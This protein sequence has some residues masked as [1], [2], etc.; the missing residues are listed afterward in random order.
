M[1]VPTASA[2][3]AL[4]LVRGESALPHDLLGAHPITRDGVDGV[5]IRAFQ[6]N[7][8]S[9]VVVLG[10]QRWP[11][12]R[13][14]HGL[15]AVFL[16]DRTAP[17]AYRL[18]ITFGDGRTVLRDDPYRFLPTLGE[19]DLHLFNEGRHLRLWE[20][21]GAHLCEID[22]VV[23]TSFAVW[24]PNATRV[25]VIGAFNGWDGRAHQMRLL[26]ASGVF[27]LF[28]PGVGA[29]AM[30]KFEIRSPSG[31]L[32]V[33]TD[34]YAFK[35][36]PGPGHA[37][38][39]QARD[40]YDWKD[41]AWLA[42][43]ADADP[44]REPM[45]VYEVH[46]G[47]WMRGEHNRLLTYRE[48]APRLAE[49][50]KRM[51]FTHVELL[52]VLEHPFG[53]S[54]GYQVGGYFAPTSR[55]GSPDDFRA[56]VDTMHEAGIG[57]LLDW[58]P[59]HFPKDDW[60]LRRFDGT[61][62]YEHED[63]RL[64]D[65]PEWGT[66]I[67]NYARYEVRNFLLANALYWIEEFHIDGLRVDAVASMLYLDYGREAGQ[68]LR[69]RFGGRE[70][71]EAVSFLKQLNHAV[72]SLHPGVIT[73]AEEST[74]W[75][76]VTHPISEGGLGFT[77]KWNMGWMH[78]TL[79]YFK[80]DPFFRKGAH[81][82]LTFAMMYEY[83][84]RFMNPLSHDEV[85]HLKK[86]LVEKMPGDIWQ[87]FANL[88]ALI[89]YSITRPGKSLFF[90]GT[91]L[92]SH[93][94]W[95]HDIS[96]EWH[97]MGDARRQGLM[98][99]MEALGALYRQ[100]ACFWRRDHE[101]SGF[102]WIDVSDKEQSVLSYARYDGAS[103]AIVVLNLT[104]VPRE[105][106]RLGAPAMGTYHVVL[107]SDAT[108][109]GGS[110]YAVAETAEA[111]LMPYHGFPQSL[112]VSLPPLSMLVL[113]PAEQSDARVVVDVVALLPEPGTSRS[114]QEKPVK[115]PKTPKPAK[116][117]KREKEPKPAKEPKREKAPKPTKE[118]KREKAPKPAKEPKR[119][120]APKPAKEPKREKSA[121]ASK[122]EKAVAETAVTEKAVTEAKARQPETK[123]ARK[124][125][126]KT[127]AKPTLA[128]RAS[129]T[130]VR[131]ASRP[132][133]RKTRP[134]KVT[135]PPTPPTNES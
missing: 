73:V 78:D 127:A 23:G 44:L 35:M 11:M 77:L 68:W 113:L 56:F 2:A 16:S 133:P 36:E 76:K 42:Q 106:Y 122:P 9:I 30:Y 13:D 26:G 84:E 101:P 19:M 129:T 47:S 22:G 114:K 95:N 45:L 128:S 5:A 121:K 6:P 91:E 125:A 64:G 118:P 37:S 39:V 41:G 4:R 63:P 58:V 72:H 1:T 100:H 10:E 99:F 135:P 53:G 134:T 108:A 20:K 27:E 104:P 29:G 70:N 59:A 85:V 79:D 81:D 110:G 86:S 107:N 65:H 112:T 12:E 119:E 83:S 43:R 132:T 87:R 24:A 71:L 28:V 7:A 96:L 88:R 117:P 14:E 116:E 17:M 46:L 57:V 50:V 18:E 40:T 80:V 60:A 69:N 49:H 62:C 74:S 126:S 15:F 130:A 111:E 61:A 89:G 120:K 38:I 34:P 98:A 82:K 55:H 25:S 131:T 90:M 105:A 109:F 97:L 123:P 92:G 66:H 31:A 48:L 3:A 67:F 8:A 33:K 93:H 103:H 94:E 21:L 124:P 102:G 51:G 115:A 32:R 75:P 54:W 52:P